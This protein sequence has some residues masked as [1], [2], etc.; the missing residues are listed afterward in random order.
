M[1]GNSIDSS[2]SSVLAKLGVDQNAPKQDKN[3]LGQD[4]FLKLMVAQLRNQDPFKPMENGDFIAQMAQFSSVS[5]IDTLQKSF[6]N[7]AASMQ[8][9]QALQAST[10]VGRNV[11][12]ASNAIALG[13]D[14]SAVNGLVKLP[15][16]AGNVRI[17]I[18]GIN[19]ELLR[20][21]PM[22]SH[23]AGDVAFSWDGLDENG[24]RLPP[25]RYNVAA[26]AGDGEDAIGLETF[27]NAH[28]D[29]VSLNQQDRSVTLNLK[30][31][32]SISMSD[33]VEIR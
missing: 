10:M 12:V 20:N 24:N 17:G 18:L 19:G 9:N 11:L 8:S 4:D 31:L 30:D 3:K 21:I 5:G 25:G 23:A 2:V 14:G 13:A 7:F 32:G 29:S 27:I 22:G 1:A 33:V 6:T 16:S 15:N 26:L 28:V